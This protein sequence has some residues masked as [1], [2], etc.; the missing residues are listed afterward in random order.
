MS[1][2]DEMLNKPE[3]IKTIGYL[4]ESEDHPSRLDVE[5]DNGFKYQIEGVPKELY[6]EFEKSASWS[7]FFTLNIFYQYKDKTT[8]IRPE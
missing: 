8:V 2:I 3:N 4:N 1:L 5:F 7:T 6:R